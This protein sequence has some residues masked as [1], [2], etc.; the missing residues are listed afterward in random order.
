MNRK[1]GA[2]IEDTV[3]DCLE[4]GAS[5]NEEEKYGISDAEASVGLYVAYDLPVGKTGL[6]SEI[7]RI[8]S[9]QNDLL[10]SATQ[11]SK[12]RP[13]ALILLRRLPKK[14]KRVLTNKFN[15]KCFRKQPQIVRV[16]NF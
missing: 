13:A 7:T 15:H 12:M 14:R 9:I 2:W 16:G 4:D 5:Q 6:V 1:S 3:V 10:Y 11:Q 8:Q